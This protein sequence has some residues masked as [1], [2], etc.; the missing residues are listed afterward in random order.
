MMKV[1]EISLKNIAM[2]QNYTLENDNLADIDKIYN[3]RYYI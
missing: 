2:I 1:L 3:S